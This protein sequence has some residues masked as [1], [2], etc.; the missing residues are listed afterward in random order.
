M[1]QIYLDHN[2]TTPP[3]PKVVEAM[4]PFFTSEFGNA[5]SVHS[6]GRQAKT[7]VLEARESIAGALGAHPEEIVF[8]SGG[9]ESDTLAIQGTAYG[10]RHKGHHI[11]TSRIEHHAVLHTCRF[12]QRE[13]FEVTYVSADKT[14]LI[15]PAEVEHAIRGETILVTVM[16]ANNEVGT[17]Q[18]LQEIGSIC[19]EKGVPFHT[20]AVQAFGKIPVDVETLHVDLLSLSGHKIYGPKGTG[21]LYIGE[22]NRLSLF[23]TAG[24][25]N[26][27]AGPARRTCPASSD[28]EPRPGL[29][30][31]TCLQRLRDCPVFAICSRRGSCPRS[32]RSA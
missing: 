5:S 4:I 14:G 12:L 22:G 3:H 18:P 2:A 20:D 29:P 9:T 32:I 1:K 27:A 23:F 8:T 31:R 21:A 28:W 13:G 7:A 17:I 24:I 30:W 16:H 6:F 10:S 25:T 19:R 15:D 26:K 11:I